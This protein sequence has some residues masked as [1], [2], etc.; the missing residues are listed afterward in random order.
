MAT[1][2]TQHTDCKV[3]EALSSS[4]AK[5]LFKQ[6]LIAFDSFG[7]FFISIISCK[8]SHIESL[9]HQDP[10]EWS[11]ARPGL[12]AYSFTGASKP[13]LQCCF[14]QEPN[15]GAFTN[16]PL[17]STRLDID[18][19]ICDCCTVMITVMSVMM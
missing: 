18:R 17:G 9:K 3:S 5:A 7:I 11:E 6:E 4:S 13:Q 2:S 14:L 15:G 16:K 8:A 1:L 19:N 10:L 12:R